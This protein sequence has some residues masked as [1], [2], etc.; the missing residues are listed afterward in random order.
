MN[1]IAKA[2]ADRDITHLDVVVETKEVKVAIENLIHQ[3]FPNV[4][5]ERIS[6]SIFKDTYWKT[7]KPYI[8]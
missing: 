7:I 8:T 3:H 6:V 1:N 2:M 5:K 4:P